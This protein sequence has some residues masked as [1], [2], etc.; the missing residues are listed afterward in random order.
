MAVVDSLPQP[1]TSQQTQMGEIRLD[2]LQKDPLRAKVGMK[3]NLHRCG[4]PSWGT[5]I[6]AE[7]PP[8][9]CHPAGVA[10]AEIQSLNPYR[11][12]CPSRYYYQHYHRRRH[13][14]GE[15]NSTVDPDP[16]ETGGQ[17]GW[18]CCCS[19]SRSQ[20]QTARMYPTWYESLIC[21]DSWTP[22]GSQT[23]GMAT[24]PKLRLIPPLLTIL[25]KE[26]WQ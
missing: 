6:H 20:D 11:H 26:G 14:S 2:S 24:K 3:S 8:I 22:R 1:A 16:L 25:T 10:E 13:S 12:R 21:T 15:A 17:G 19:G 9:R 4:E 18:C 23:P 7:L 5:R